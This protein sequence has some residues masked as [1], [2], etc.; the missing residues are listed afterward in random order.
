MP[1]QKRKTKEKKGAA[2]NHSAEFQ[3]KTIPALAAYIDRI[4]AEQL[5]FRRFMVKEHKGK[6]Y[7]ERAIIRIVNGEIKCSSKEYEPTDEEH[8]LI[9]GALM[10]AN[11][12]KSVGAKDVFLLLD[13]MGNDPQYFEFCN[14]QTGEII[15]VQ[16]RVQLASGD[17]AYLP[18]TFW[19]D[20]EWRMMEPDGPLPFWKPK[21]REALSNKIMIHE[22]AKPASFVHD[23]ISDEAACK[24]HPWGAA[25]KEY[26]HWGMIGG[27]LAPHR[28]DYDELARAKPID[29]VYFCDNDWPGMNALQEIARIYSGKLKG[30]KVD[31]RWP[32][33]WDCADPMPEAF[34]SKGRYIGPSL[35][36]L[37]EPATWATEVLPSPTG[38]GRN[39]AV[40]RRA[41]REEW[42]HCIQPE[43]FIHVD[44]PNRIYTANEFNN[45]VSPFSNADDTARLL[46]KD[47]VAKGI[48]LKYDP[49]SRPGIYGS[50]ETGRYI[51]TYCPSKIKPEKG[52]PKPFLDFMKMLIPEK[53]D[54]EEMMRWC[55]TLI[56]R[57]GTKMLYGALLISEQQGIGKGTL[58]EKILGPLVGLDNVSYPSESEIVD[59][60]FNYWLAHKRLAVVHEIYAGHSSKGYNKLKSIITDRHLTVSKKYQSN[61][62]IEN[63]IHIFAC[64]NS[65]RAV[66]LS[67][68]DRRW[69]LP[70]VTEEKKP[71]AY[72]SKL[73][74][75]LNMQGG[76]PIIAWWAEE[77]L[78]TNAPVG[79]GAAAPWSAVKQ[80]AIE[81]GLSQGSLFVSEFLDRVKEEMNGKPVI[82][83]DKDLVDLIRQAVHQGRETDYLEKPLTLR[84]L[85]KS[86]GWYVGKDKVTSVPVPWRPLPCYSFKMICSLEA[87]SLKTPEQLAAEGKKPELAGEL[88]KK[89]AAM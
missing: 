79:M 78:K 87:D 39:I 88:W 73:N 19:S 62:D 28:A 38:K 15:M 60:N 82:L 16:Q 1:S 8:A 33:S 56:A 58:G 59:S 77:W 63:W 5:N 72:W 49:S 89:L 52:D 32:A 64:S 46:K 51:N 22:G 36:E 12:P 71:Q 7:I 4:G 10:S 61:Y 75:W 6:Y 29:T 43:V 85:A 68:D 30:A 55:A 65:M 83:L 37:I 2:H 31:K 34:F 26:E 18:W 25:L 50:A 41:F 45:K 14:R 11:F 24:K 23:L 44:W 86:K 67:M 74:N 69:F 35:E 76:L 40:T 48:V 42:F 66:Q 84:R 27:A 54:C 70:A 47:S 20:G 81:E 53:K 80:E 9:K 17:K 57:P 13:K 21:G 3:Y